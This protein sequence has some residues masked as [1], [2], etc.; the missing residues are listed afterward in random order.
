MSR[1]RGAYAGRGGLPH[2]PL[3]LLCP[4][5]YQLAEL[6]QRLLKRST[7][8]LEMEAAELPQR[9]LGLVLGLVTRDD[10]GPMEIPDGVH[11]TVVDQRQALVDGALLHRGSLHSRWRPHHRSAG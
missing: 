2:T 11:E 7:L 6:P 1:G 3:T 8:H 9:H 4:G 10:V 5:S